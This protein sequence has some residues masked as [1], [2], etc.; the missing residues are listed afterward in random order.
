MRVTFT[1]ELS[2]VMSLTACEPDMTAKLC[3]SATTS[4]RMNAPAGRGRSTATASQT[5]LP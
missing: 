4:F 2:G 5:D 1:V 3:V